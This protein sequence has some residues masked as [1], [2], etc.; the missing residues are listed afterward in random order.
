M[1]KSTIQ[2]QWRANKAVMVQQKTK[3]IRLRTDCECTKDQM[4]I[5]TNEQQIN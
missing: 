2:M 3:P 4:E 1:L 5:E